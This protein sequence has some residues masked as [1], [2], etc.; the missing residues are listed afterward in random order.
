MGLK[1]TRST[2]YSSFI[3]NCQNCGPPIGE[4]INKLWHIRIMEYYLE[5]R[6]N[7]LSNYQKIWRKLKC[8][9][10][11]ERSQSDKARYCTIPSI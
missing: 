1:G 11:S 7:E 5:L 8:I 10:L 6:R 9:M 3:P 4:W 2:V